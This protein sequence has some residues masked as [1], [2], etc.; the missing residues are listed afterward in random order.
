[1]R[2]NSDFHAMKPI[3]T[4]IVK[5]EGKGPPVFYCERIRVVGLTSKS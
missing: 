1:M 3:M 4:P 2:E 5:E